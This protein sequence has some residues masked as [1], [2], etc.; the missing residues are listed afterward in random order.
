MRCSNTSVRQ[1]SS[2]FKFCIWNDWSTIR[3]EKWQ[4]ATLR[5]RH[6]ITLSAQKQQ[7]LIWFFSCSFFNRVI[8]F[9]SQFSFSLEPAHSWHGALSLVQAVIKKK[10]MESASF[11]CRNLIRGLKAHKLVW[12][13]SDLIWQ[14]LMLRWAKTR[15]PLPLPGRARY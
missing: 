2:F 11:A 12:F 1:F 3:F 7:K 9:A 13:L 6:F 4:V 15:S 14:F 5:V 10:S 8:H